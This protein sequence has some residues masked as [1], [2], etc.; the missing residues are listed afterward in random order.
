MT[1]ITDVLMLIQRDKVDVYCNPVNYHYL[2]PYVS[3]WR[4]IFFH[5]LSDE[6]VNSSIFYSQLCG[7]VEPLK[8]GTSVNRNSLETEQLARSRFFTFYFYCIKIS[9]N[10]NTSVPETRQAFYYF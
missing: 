7:T 8:T 2:L 10:Q 1:F 3:H 4:N 6:Q 5:C 9:V